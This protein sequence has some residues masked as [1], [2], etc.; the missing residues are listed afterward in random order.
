M[1][2][3]GGRAGS[4][5]LQPRAHNVENCS[6]FGSAPL[7]IACIKIPKWAFS[8]VQHVEMKRKALTTCSEPAF[9]T[10][11]SSCLLSFVMCFQFILFY[12]YFR[13]IGPV[14]KYKNL[15]IFFFFAAA[16]AVRED[17]KIKVLEKLGKTESV[18]FLLCHTA[19]G[20][21]VP[22]QYQEI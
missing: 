1:R 14:V 4:Q 12:C 22:L 3:E 15:D 9:Q 13:L 18:C 17:K 20:Y 16:I 11:Q 7:V 8:A 21:L 2:T 6:C 19:A 5:H 10:P